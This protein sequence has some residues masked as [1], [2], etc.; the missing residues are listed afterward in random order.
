MPTGT[1]PYATE[2]TQRKRF[3]GLGFK[4][5]QAAWRLST[6]VCDG[7]RRTETGPEQFV[8]AISRSGAKEAHPVRGLNVHTITASADLAIAVSLLALT[9]SALR[10]GRRPRRARSWFLFTLASGTLVA[11]AAFALFD[12]MS[13][14]SAGFEVLTLG[15]FAM[16]L[17]SLY[18]AEREQQRTIEQHAERDATTGLLNRRAFRELAADR[19][20]ATSAS[21]ALAVLDLDGFKRVNDSQG[22]PAGDRILEVVA[23]AIRANL[24]PSDIAARYGGDEFVVFLEGC[25]LDEARRIM[26]RIRAI[27]ATVTAASGMSVTVSVGLASSRGVAGE[28]DQLIHAA[29]GALIAV[30]QTGKDQLRVAEF[31]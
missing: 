10:G 28:L 20:A 13:G 4:G 26:Q 3:W 1:L 6:R 24:R 16:G 9:I 21:S 23:A 25:S 8:V 27:V 12:E 2:A 15:L 19:L 5:S 18:G 11:H 31:A 29:D 30:K 17:A 22:H 14:A 7:F